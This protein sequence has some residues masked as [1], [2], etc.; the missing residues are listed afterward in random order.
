[1]RTAPLTTVQAGISRLR[2]KGGSRADSLYDLVNG[3]VTQD[4]SVVPRGGA[5]RTARLSSTTHGLCAFNGSR[6]V[7]STSIQTLVSPYICLVVAHPTDNTQDI[8]KF[9][10]H[11]HSSVSST[12]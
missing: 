1:M 2:L 5:R 6:Y 11:N 3:R 10:S 4:G 12:R 8:K 9:I 7:F